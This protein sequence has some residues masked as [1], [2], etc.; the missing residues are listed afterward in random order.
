MDYHSNCSVKLDVNRIDSEIV[1]KSYDFVVNL[2]ENRLS[3]DFKFHSI[4]HTREVLKYVQILG[5]YKG[6]S[7]QKMNLLKVSAIF[8]DVGYI[9]AYKGHEKEGVIIARKFLK[10]NKINE[11]QIQII[12]DAILSTKLPQ[13]P[14]NLYSKILCDA[15]LINLTYD[16]YFKNAELLRQEWIKTGFAEMSEKE[17]H[18]N[19][20]RFFKMHNYHTD[21]GRNVLDVKKKKVLQRI[22]KRLAKINE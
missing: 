12:A 20:V 14:K 22:Q 2:F 3:S 18:E 19:S 7:E 17:F 5:K 8:H 21:Y 13:K 15:D 9:N 4:A 6:F 11:Q 16:D 10:K 1:K